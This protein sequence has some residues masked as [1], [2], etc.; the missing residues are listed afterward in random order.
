[1]SSAITFEAQIT[2]GIVFDN[3][4]AI[5]GSQGHQALAIGEGHERAGGVLEGR[6][7]VDEFGVDATALEVSEHGFKGIDVH[8][9]FA[10][11][12]GF[13]FGTGFLE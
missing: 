2:V 11:G 12:D 1:V 6:R 9:I 4:D 7:G 3:Q 10:D 5:L 8:T 13:D